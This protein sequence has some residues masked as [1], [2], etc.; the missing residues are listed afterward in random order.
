MWPV[1]CP[2]VGVGGHRVSVCEHALVY[3][4]IS[5]YLYMKTTLHP[6]YFKK[7]MK[8]MNTLI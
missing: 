6:F 2:H 8:K 5:V 4:C 1:V 3:V 7:E